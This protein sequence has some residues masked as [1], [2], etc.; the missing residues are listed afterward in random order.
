MEKYKLS[1]KILLCLY[2]RYIRIITPPSS[3][4]SYLLGMSPQ[5]D[6][7]GRQNTTIG[8]LGTLLNL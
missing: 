2:L 4:M 6:Q 1:Q 3:L 7:H 5:T 8:I